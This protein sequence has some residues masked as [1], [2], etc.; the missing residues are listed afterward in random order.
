MLKNDTPVRIAVNV[1][2]A[3]LTV[4]GFNIAIVSFQI[5][6]L[7]RM[8]GESMS[9]A[10]VPLPFWQQFT[11]TGDPGSCLSEGFGVYRC[12]CL[13]H[14]DLWGAGGE[15]D[16]IS[17]LPADKYYPWNHVPCRVACI[18]LVELPGLYI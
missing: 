8:S 13:V 5:S 18:F 16:S 1:M 2:R 3:C 4:I 7:Y 14:G 11:R 6:Q 17:F 9:P 10:R 15:L 12:R